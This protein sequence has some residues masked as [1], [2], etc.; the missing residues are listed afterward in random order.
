[1]LKRGVFK[2]T[3]KELIEEYNKIIEKR[4]KFNDSTIIDE[5]N[6][7]LH[8]INTKIKNVV[9]KIAEKDQE[10]FNRLLYKFVIEFQARE[11]DEKLDSFIKLIIS[12]ASRK[13]K[14]KNVIFEA[15][16]DD[17]IL[18]SIYEKQGYFVKCR[19]QQVSYTKYYRLDYDSEGYVLLANYCIDTKNPIFLD[20][21]L[22]FVENKNMPF[23]IFE[24]LNISIKRR[25]I[26]KDIYEILNK[27]INQIESK[28]YK[29]YLKLKLDYI[30]GIDNEIGSSLR[31][32]DLFDLYEDNYWYNNIIQL[33]VKNYKND[34]IKLVR[35]ILSKYF[36]DY[37][38]SIKSNQIFMVIRSIGMSL[39]SNK[40][41]YKLVTNNIE[42]YVKI[43]KNLNVYTCSE[44]YGYHFKYFDLALMYNDFILMDNLLDALSK[45]KY[46]NDFTDL[47]HNLLS[48]K[49][50]LSYEMIDVLNRWKDRCDTVVDDYLKYYNES[51]Y[52]EHAISMIDKYELNK[53]NENNEIIMIFNTSLKAIEK[54]VEDVITILLAIESKIKIADNINNISKELFAYSKL[55]KA[56][57]SY[58]I[59][60]YDMELIFKLL[61]NH[62]IPKELITILNSNLIMVDKYDQDEE[63]IYKIFKLDYHLKSNNFRNSG[64]L[65]EIFT[66][67]KQELIMEYFQ[68]FIGNIREKIFLM[69]D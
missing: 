14:E 60:N 37:E 8:N 61:Q 62:T 20:K 64:F 45:N 41:F 59:E 7:S 52:L 25:K 36:D 29:M 34:I 66:I 26:S 31:T 49:P 2:M 63:Q 50:N 10:L 39:R 58:M 27:Y 30:S 16:S 43:L 48:S 11:D 6:D 5:E 44:G 13:S 24:I 35:Y 33:F 28:K 23:F 32:I 67:M 56:L 15:F 53:V 18:K 1:M 68:C 57:F 51:S 3:H 54:N 38:D 21:L 42:E 65:L 17:K 46:L 55:V 69:T 47:Y 22:K 40:L 19:I 4:R 9:F 12:H